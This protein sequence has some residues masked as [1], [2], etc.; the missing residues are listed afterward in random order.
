MLQ[1]LALLTAFATREGVSL[2][3][4]DV[5]ICISTIYIYSNA[6]ALL[7]SKI[8]YI[9]YVEVHQPPPA[10]LSPHFFVVVVTAAVTPEFEFLSLS[11]SKLVC[12]ILRVCTV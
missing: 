3:S 12:N 10:G 11:L 1:P 5:H 8:H 6:L 2:F 7:Y 4:F 9:A